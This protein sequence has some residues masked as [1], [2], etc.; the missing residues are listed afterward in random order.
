MHLLSKDLPS[1]VGFFDCVAIIILV[2]S[3]V[4]VDIHLPENWPQ[5]DRIRMID[6]IL[7]E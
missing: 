7:G 6:F 5:V 1:I 3:W 2:C 4:D